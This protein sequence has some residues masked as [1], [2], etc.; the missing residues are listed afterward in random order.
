M[1][2]FGN[3]LAGLEALSSSL[4]R[5]IERATTVERQ[6]PKLREN[7]DKAKEQIDILDRLY[8][9]NEETSNVFSEKFGRFIEAVRI[10]AVDVNKL[11]QETG[12]FSIV[13]EGELV[14]IRDLFSGA[15]LGKYRQEIQDFIR[16]LNTG[17]ADIGDAVTF[18]E[19]RAGNLAKGLV[20]VLK[21]FQQGKATLEEVQRALDAARKT[22]PPGGESG[23]LLEALEDLAQGGR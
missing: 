12:D 13:I 9:A 16:E 3:T 10:G 5:V 8:A 1:P 17:K 14:R 4:D 11:K 21:A 19:E 22:F 20:N 15:D 2:R 18:I 7:V 23:A 6:A